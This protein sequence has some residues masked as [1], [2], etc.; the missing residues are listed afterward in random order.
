MLKRYKR[1]YDIQVIQSSTKAFQLW[2]TANPKRIPANLN[3]H[4]ESTADGD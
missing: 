4:E 2:I 3:C 1:L